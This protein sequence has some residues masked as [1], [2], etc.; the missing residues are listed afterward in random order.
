[1]QLEEKSAFTHSHK[2]TG[3]TLAG[4]SLTKIQ[5]IQVLNLTPYY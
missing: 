2:L 5:I 4:N 3:T 1:M